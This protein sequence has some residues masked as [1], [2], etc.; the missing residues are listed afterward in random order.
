[1]VDISLAVMS[2]LRSKTAITDLVGANIFFDRLPQGKPEDAIVIWTITETAHTNLGGAQGLDQSVMQ[3]DAMGRTRSDANALAWTIWT[4]LDPAAGPNPLPIVQDQIQISGI[5]R[6]SGIRT[7][8]N[9]VRSG[10]D[11]YQFLA[12]QDLQFSYCSL[13]L[14]GE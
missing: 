2:L 8:T 11:E 4:Q 3:V 5:H 6:L 9:R 12:T 1:M 10:T 13:E 14:V 7:P